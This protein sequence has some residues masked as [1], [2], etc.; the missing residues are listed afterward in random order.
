MLAAETRLLEQF[1]AV[2]VE[3]LAKDFERRLD[4]NGIP[5]GMICKPD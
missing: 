5:A 2:T 1:A 4:K 3:D